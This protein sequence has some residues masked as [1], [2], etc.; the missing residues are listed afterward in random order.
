MFNHSLWTGRHIL[1]LLH[2][3]LSQGET[4][5]HSRGD[6]PTLLKQMMMVAGAQSHLLQSDW[7]EMGIT[8][9]TS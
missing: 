8:I 6:N 9:S 4:F 2:F 5:V 7:I 1:K 3:S